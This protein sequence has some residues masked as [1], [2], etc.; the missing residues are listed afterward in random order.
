MGGFF[1]F[2]MFGGGFADT[3]I[4]NEASTFLTAHITRKEW[5]SAVQTADMQH[6]MMF[7]EQHQV[8]VS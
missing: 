2:G 7:G 3:D 8:E 5:N 6:M 1:V 4:L